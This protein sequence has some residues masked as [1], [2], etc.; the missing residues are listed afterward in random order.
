M[1]QKSGPKTYA[2]RVRIR[3]IPYSTVEPDLLGNDQLVTKSAYGPEHPNNEPYTKLGFDVDEGS[4]EFKDAQEDYKYGELVDL[5][6]RDYL[7]YKKAGAIIDAEDTD[8]LPELDETVLNPLVASVGE[9]AEWIRQ[10]KPNANDVVQASQGNPDVAAK[11]LQAESDAHDG[12]P[13][14]G[15]VKGLQ[16]VISRG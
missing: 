5:V 11:L 12:E 1:A 4:Q 6:E 2:V 16:T 3:E 15:V 13:R 8:S 10:E 7:R 14:T 9:L